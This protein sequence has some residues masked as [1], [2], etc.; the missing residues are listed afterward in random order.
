M[1]LDATAANRTIYKTK[2]DPNIIYLDMEKQLQIK[3]SIF[4]DNTRTPFRDKV[5][6]CIFYDPPHDFGAPPFDHT[7]KMDDTT[8]DFI[9]HHP[10]C[11]TYYGWDKYKNQQELI[12]HIYKA[13][14]EFH[15]ILK[16]D[17]LLRFK[18]CEIKITLSRTLT[19][20]EDW[21]VLMILNIADPTKTWG[22]KKAY[23]VDLTK[24]KRDYKQIDLTD[25][26]FAG[27]SD[28]PAI[29]VS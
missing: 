17:G 25:A 8:R 19:L 16:D 10:F 5:I 7:L 12:I 24:V 3:P 1:I 22:T 27:N 18:W 4:A 9:K 14:K 29:N 21:N 26:K 13:Q 11:T 28:N 6:D 23:W 20:F 2:N 15:R